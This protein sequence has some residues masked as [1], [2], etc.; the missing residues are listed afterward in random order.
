MA[1]L[2]WGRMPI[3]LSDLLAVT[4][5]ADRRV[6]AVVVAHASNIFTSIEC[7]QNIEYR[8]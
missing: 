7:I 3:C 1:I 5:T 6:I 8:G 4:K 2:E